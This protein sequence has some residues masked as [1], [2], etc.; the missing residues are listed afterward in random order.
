MVD[1]VEFDIKK[2][3]VYEDTTHYR[4]A[5][6]DYL[7]SWMLFPVW[8][9]RDRFAVMADIRAGVFFFKYGTNSILSN[10]GVEAKTAV[11]DL[12]AKSVP[13]YC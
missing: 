11:E 5:T 7:I 3:H 10:V 12:S 2:L 4:S 6:I 13:R 1:T 9:T 8:P